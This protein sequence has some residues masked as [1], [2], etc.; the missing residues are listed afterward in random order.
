M[1][2]PQAAQRLAARI[3]RH[4]LTA[5]VRLLVDAHRPLAPLIADMGTAIGPWLGM[6][7]GGPGEELRALAEEPDGLDRLVEALERPPRGAPDANSG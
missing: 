7:A 2:S 4:R 3:E 6:A 1:T 5:P